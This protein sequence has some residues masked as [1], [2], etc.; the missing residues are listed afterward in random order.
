M[1]QIHRRVEV[2]VDRM[3]TVPTTKRLFVS[4][5][6]LDLP[7]V[8]TG[9]GRIGRVDHEQWHSY[10]GRQQ[11]DSIAKEPCCVTLPSDESLGIFNCYRSTRL[12]CHGHKPTSFLAQQL[13]LKCSIRPS[14]NPMLLLHGSAVALFLQDGTQI[15]PLVSIGAHHTRSH[16]YI[17]SNDSTCFL[18]FRQR[19][20]HSYVSVPL[21]SFPHDK[22]T[23]LCSRIQDSPRKGKRP[24]EPV[25]PFRWDIQLIFRPFEQNPIV[26]ASGLLG[27][28][29]VST[30]NE[31][32]FQCSW[33][34]TS[35]RNTSVV[36]I[37]AA[38]GTPDEL[39]HTFG[40]RWA[41]LL[42]SQNGCAGRMRALEKGRQK[43]Q[44][45]SLNASRKQL[46]LV[47]KNNG[48]HTKSIAKRPPHL[49]SADF[50]S[51][52]HC[53][54]IGE[55]RLR[56]GS[57][58]FGRN[59]YPIP[60]SEAKGFRHSTDSTIKHAEEREVILPEILD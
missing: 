25:M 43:R 21:P 50:L 42:L 20:G 49:K 53:P 4:H 32:G 51:G 60:A 48:L 30:V 15:T 1:T 45:I 14:I 16:P 6:S 13:L 35:L 7:A 9:G 34:V 33:S 2:T 58:M 17:N 24:I 5:C 31:F 40:A 39:A 52:R 3:T 23:S 37:G 19:N 55:P 10:D 38:V 46:N 56:F 57:P 28:L 41:T 59:S 26:K 18:H 36:D 27:Q 54:Q 29:Q 11:R 44:G 47:A 22:G 12:L 8:R